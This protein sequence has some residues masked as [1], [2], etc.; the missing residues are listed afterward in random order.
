MQVLYTPTNEQTV[1]FR[2][3]YTSLDNHYTMDVSP[4]N[5]MISAIVNKALFETQIQTLDSLLSFLN[6]KGDID[7]MDNITEAIA[8]FKENL[9]KEYIPPS[10]V[11]AK[12]LDE[13]KSD[14]VHNNNNKTTDNKSGAKKKGKGGVKS[15]KKKVSEDSSEEGSSEVSTATRK[16]R[17]PSA[18]T[19]FIKHKMSL[20]KSELQGTEATGKNLMKL[21]STAWKD[22]T[23]EDQKKL[24]D[25]FKAILEKY[26]DD[27]TMDDS[28][29]SAL[30]AKEMY[31]SVFG[32]VQVENNDEKVT[33]GVEDEE[34]DVEVSDS[35]E[36]LKKLTKKKTT[37]DN[38]KMKMSKKPVNESEDSDN[39]DESDDDA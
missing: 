37:C 36:V 24:K 22:V 23:E 27:D 19:M 14:V 13:I 8:E 20:L 16:K 28:E 18:Y 31:D 6:E 32:N 33:D 29:K 4:V 34:E 3:I 39:A 38:K 25:N 12:A 35:D 5:M 9:Q 26:S 2:A 10:G 7:F 11:T 21:A 17:A 15:S 30:M 1:L